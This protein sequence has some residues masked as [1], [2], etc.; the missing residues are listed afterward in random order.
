MTGKC[1]SL[2]REGLDEGARRAK[3]R[4]KGEESAAER[5]ENRGFGRL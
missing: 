4:S 1:P 2:T 5:Q 3:L